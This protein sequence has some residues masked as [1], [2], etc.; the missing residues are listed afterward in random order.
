MNRIYHKVGIQATA[1]RIFNALTTQSGLAG[2]W[3]NEVTGAFSGGHSRPGETIRCGFGSLGSMEMEVDELSR[4]RKVRWECKKGPE[5]WIGSHIEFTLEK[6]STNDQMTIVYFNHQDWKKESEFMGHC[7][8]KWA[9]FLLSL[10][11]LIEKGEGNPSP[12]DVKI[13]DWN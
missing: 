3:T 11:S 12:N 2:W 6:S 7:S 13:D 5:D 10:K 9:V 8:M 1:E 4:E